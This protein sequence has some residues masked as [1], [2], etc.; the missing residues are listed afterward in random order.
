MGEKQKKHMKEKKGE[1]E[2]KKRIARMGKRRQLGMA[3]TRP[4]LLAKSTATPTS[5]VFLGVLDVVFGGD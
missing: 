3:Q 4:Y 2:D 5:T 1:N